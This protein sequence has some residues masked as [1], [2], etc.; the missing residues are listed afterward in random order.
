MERVNE[1]VE[2]KQLESAAASYS[3]LKGLYL[4]P[5]GLLFVLAA[6]ANW[7][8]GPLRHVWVFPAAALV[9]A[10]ACLPIARYYHE[11]YGRV[12]PSSRQQARGVVAVI[13]SLAV[14]V[15]GSL[16]LRSEASWS[17]DL[18]VNATAASFAVVMLASNAIQVGLKAHHWTIWG[19]V[20]VVGLLPVWDGADPSN[21]GLVLAG[22]AVM[23]TGV[24]DHRLLV[25]TFGSAKVLNLRDGDA[26][27]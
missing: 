5:L 24:F 10:A 14:M 23:A 26:G 1:T 17:L 27:A 4:I 13:V 20:L 2:R 21:V 18:P 6:L 11:N 12:R 16:L 19:S 9:V 3:Y 7:E 8:V 25:R 22:V 15:G